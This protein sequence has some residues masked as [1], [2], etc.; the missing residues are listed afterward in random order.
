L[1]FEIFL[2]PAFS[3]KEKGKVNVSINLTN[4]YLLVKKFFDGLSKN[5]L[6]RSYYIFAES[7]H[8][9]PFEKATT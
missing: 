8:L 7:N 1:F 9:T 4:Q 3:Q 6:Y 2:I 5:G